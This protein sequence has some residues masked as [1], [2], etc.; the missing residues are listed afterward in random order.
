MGPDHLMQC[1]EIWN[2]VVKDGL[3]FP[4]MELLD[5]KTG[6]DFFDSQSFTGAAIDPVTGQTVGLYILH[7]N[8][9]GRCGH[10]CNASFAVRKD[11]RGRQIGEALVRHCLVQAKELGFGILQFNAVV[12]D[13]QRALTLYK[14]IGFTPLGIIPKGFLSIDG[15]YKDIIPHYIEL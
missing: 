15:T 6:S 3:A 2:D 4:Q 10:L 7:P 5:E 8:N 13:N 14:K 9:V 11:Q 1:I 12:A